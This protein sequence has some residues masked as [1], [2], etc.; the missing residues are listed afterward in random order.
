MI[1]SFAALEQPSATTTV[2]SPVVAASSKGDIIALGSVNGVLSV[3]DYGLREEVLKINFGQY[4]R[5]VLFSPNGEILAASLESTPDMS[6]VLLNAA[7][8]EELLK[9]D[10]IQ[11]NWGLKTAFSPDGALFATVG[12]KKGSR[13]YQG[14]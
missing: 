1:A 2:A 13:L 10:H 14:P 9:I 7:T 12:V 4:T 6:L 11:S 8:G 5:N 3:Y